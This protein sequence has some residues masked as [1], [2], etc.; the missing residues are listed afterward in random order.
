MYQI[1]NNVGVVYDWRSLPVLIMSTE[2]LSA[3]RA[4]VP[5][6]VHA[7]HKGLAGRVGIIGGSLE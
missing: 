1:A 2:L 3:V 4:I 5:P 6:L 7:S